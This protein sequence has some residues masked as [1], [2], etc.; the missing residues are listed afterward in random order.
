MSHEVTGARLQFQVSLLEQGFCFQVPLL[1]QGGVGDLEVHQQVA[2]GA[3]DVATVTLQI[4]VGPGL[5][6]ISHVF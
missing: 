4:N 5:R 1:E 6:P 2:A 3:V